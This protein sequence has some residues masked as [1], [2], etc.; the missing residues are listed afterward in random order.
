MTHAHE[1]SVLIRRSAEEVFSF[2]SDIPR[3]PSWRPQITEA[4]WVDPGPTDVGRGFEEIDTVLGKELRFHCVVSEWDPPRCISYKVLEGPARMEIDYWS[5]STAE[6]CRFTM[7]ARRRSRNPLMMM[8]D[9]LISRILRRQLR[10]GLERLRT[11]MESGVT[12]S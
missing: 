12:I 11:I 5:E 10:E 2:I 4:A 3:S 7:R 6:G 9:P 8:L 1:E